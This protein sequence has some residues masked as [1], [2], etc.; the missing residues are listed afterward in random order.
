[1][2]ENLYKVISSN[3]D[4]STYHFDVEL[5]A[6]H[7]IYGAHFPGNPITPGACQLEML[8]QLASEASGKDLAVLEVRSIKYLNVINPVKTPE[9]EVELD[10]TEDGEEGKIKCSAK[11][12]AEEIIFTKAIMNLE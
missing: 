12:K 4:G 7:Q 6:A 9:V 1:M 3:K 10:L 11:I 2:F 8:R 5:D